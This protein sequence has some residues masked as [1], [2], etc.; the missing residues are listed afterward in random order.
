MQCSSGKPD[1]RRTVDWEQA[2]RPPQAMREIR[3]TTAIRR[4]AEHQ[5]CTTRRVHVRPQPLRFSHRSSAT[6]ASPSSSE[7]TRPFR[8][9][10]QL[11]KKQTVIVELRTPA[12]FRG[13]DLLT[14]RSGTQTA[15]FDCRRRT[16]ITVALLPREAFA[17]LP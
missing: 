17:E 9:E 11:P 4:S 5:N 2:G 15:P 12:R 13:E 3:C 10:L 14:S 7:E 1:Q 16:I 8:S 6:T